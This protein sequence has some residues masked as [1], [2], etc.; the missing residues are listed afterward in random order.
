LHV[1]ALRRVDA[2]VVGQLIGD[3]HER[4]VAVITHH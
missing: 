1:L 4:L 2:Q 3:L